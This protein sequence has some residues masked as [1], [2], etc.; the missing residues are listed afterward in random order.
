MDNNNNSF[1]VF[2][3]SNTLSMSASDPGSLFKFCVLG[4]CF[5]F[6]FLVSLICFSIAKHDVLG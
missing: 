2:D 1:K 5:L 3:N 6:D 4:F